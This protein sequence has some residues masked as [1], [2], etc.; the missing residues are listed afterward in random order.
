MSEEVVREMT[1]EEMIEKNRKYLDFI[2]SR[3]KEMQKR[4]EKLNDS[5]KYI[6]LN[7]YGEGIT[8]GKKSMQE[9][10]KKL[11]EFWNNNRTATIMKLFDGMTWEQIFGEIEKADDKVIEYENEKEEIHVGDVI[12]DIGGVRTLLVTNV[13]SPYVYTLDKDGRDGVRNEKDV[14]KTG[15]HYPLDEFLKEL[16]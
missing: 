11:C 1:M 16:K 5:C 14:V 9:K 8:I 2:E 12:E 15:E 6:E 4:C 3:Y 10:V 13:V 7:S